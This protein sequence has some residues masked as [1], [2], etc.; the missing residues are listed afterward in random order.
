MFQDLLG[1]SHL[2]TSQSFESLNE[3]ETVAIAGSSRGL[4]SLKPLPSDEEKVPT[5]PSPSKSVSA[6]A[7]RS[8]EIS[9]YFDD[10]A[11]NDVSKPFSFVQQSHRHNTGASLRKPCSAASG[12]ESTP[13]VVTV[14][15]RHSDYATTPI[16]N[17]TA[18]VHA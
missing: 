18:G 1:I 2:D 11:L 10:M 4:P 15:P 8:P 3:E 16:G 6:A 7:G 5:S 9:S 12:C 17:E 14:K 13:S